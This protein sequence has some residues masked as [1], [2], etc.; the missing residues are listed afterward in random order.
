MPRHDKLLADIDALFGEL[1][2]SESGSEADGKPQS[3]SSLLIVAA[4][5]KTSDGDTVMTGTSFSHDEASEGSKKQRRGLSESDTSTARAASSDDSRREALIHKRGK[6][7]SDGEA[8]EMST[9]TRAALGLTYD[10]E[11]YT[12]PE[13][14]DV[15]KHKT[16]VPDLEKPDTNFGP[17]AEEMDRYT[18][19]GTDDLSAI[20][21]ERPKLQ[22]RKPASRRI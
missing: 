18:D 2:I 7:A 14:R 10:I 4:P 11:T 3:K 5:I 15:N 20:K 17:T 21:P 12:T 13:D 8:S 6:K 16:T 19:P 1:C 9:Y 22:P